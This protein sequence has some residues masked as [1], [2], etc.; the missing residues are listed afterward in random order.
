[1]AGQIR[2][3]GGDGGGGTLV[4]D[5]SPLTT[6]TEPGTIGSLVAHQA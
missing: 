1:M 3:A 5:P 2:I 6:M 4:T